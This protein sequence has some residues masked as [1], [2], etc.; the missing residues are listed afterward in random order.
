VSYL[1]KTIIDADP[2]EFNVLNHGD[3][4]SNN[5]MFQYD[6]FGKIKETYFVDFQI[7]KYGSPA[8]DLYY[9]LLSSTSF[10]NKLKHFDTFIKMYHDELVKH[11]KILQYPKKIPSLRELHISLHKYSLWGE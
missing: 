4:W 11:L 2:N 6:A 7:P 3:C 10:E 9:L 1:K 5:I 8:Q